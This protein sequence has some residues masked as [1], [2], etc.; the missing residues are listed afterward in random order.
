ML[1]RDDTVGAGV[2]LNNWGIDLLALGRALEAERLLHRSIELRSGQPGQ[3]AA[4]LPL[5]N[6]AR[7]LFELARFD[8]AATFAQR[9]Y[10]EATRVGNQDAIFKSTL[11]LARIYLG[12]HDTARAKA[13]LDVAEPAMRKLLPP[14]HVEFALLSAARAQVARERADLPAARALIDNAIEIAAQAAERGQAG[15]IYVPMLLTYRADLELTAKQFPAAEADLHR[16]L[17]LLLK[18]AQ[19]DEYSMHVGR[20]ELTLAQLL[21]SEG[22]AAEAHRQ[23]RLAIEQLTRSEGADHPETRAALELSGDLMK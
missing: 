23:A 10:Q 5:N 13:M 4:P 20:A 16:A 14:G 21:S 18:G 19:P 3:D 15:P 2:W 6:Y 1:G 11:A 7:V 8:E 22:K 12:Q 17:D 9:A